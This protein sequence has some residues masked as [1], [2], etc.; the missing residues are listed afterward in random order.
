VGAGKK[1]E[2][3]TGVLGARCGKGTTDFIPIR[4]KESSIGAGRKKKKRQAGVVVYVE[5][6]PMKVWD[7][8]TTKKTRAASSGEI[9]PRDQERGTY[10]R[11]ALALALVVHRL[12]DGEQR[13]RGQK[14]K[15]RACL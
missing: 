8:I 1:T 3:R 14:M 15:S 7:D 6:P 13:R 11:M 5:K 9:P 12:V 4:K 10:K 2:Q